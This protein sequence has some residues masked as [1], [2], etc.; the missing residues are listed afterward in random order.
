MMKPLVNRKR[1]PVSG[2]LRTP[3]SA[4]SG[5]AYAAL[6]CTAGAT[7]TLERY[8]KAQHKQLLQEGVSGIMFCNAQEVKKSISSDSFFRLH[9]IPTP[10]P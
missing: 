5:R 2:L 6:L 8:Q 10:L 9:I 4:S 3:G 7:D 1:L